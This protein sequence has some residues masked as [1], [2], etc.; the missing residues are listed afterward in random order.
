MLKDHR[1]EAHTIN[2]ADGLAIARKLWLDENY[3]LNNKI[4]IIYLII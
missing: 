1:V 4:K 2:I 3:L